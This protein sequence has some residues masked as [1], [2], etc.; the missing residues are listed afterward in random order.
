[1]EVKM[2]IVAVAAAATLVA[3]AAWAADAALSAEAA[4]ECRSFEELA[5]TF[6]DVTVPEWCA[7]VPRP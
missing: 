2:K 5:R 4:S 3:A 1:M 6:G 7:Q